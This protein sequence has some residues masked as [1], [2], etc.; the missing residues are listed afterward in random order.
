MLEDQI[1]NTPKEIKST[2]IFHEVN[3]GKGGENMD[4]ALQ[5]A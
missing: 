4:I 5:Q 3:V 1:S 2:L